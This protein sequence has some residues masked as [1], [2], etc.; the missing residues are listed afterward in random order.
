M[1]LGKTAALFSAALEFGSVIAETSD[2]DRAALKTAGE[3]FGM[4]FQIQDDL[5]DAF[6]EESSDIINKKATCLT[7]FSKEKAEEMAAYFLD[8]ALSS[9]PKNMPSIETIFL[10]YST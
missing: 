2:K 3:Q 7:L 4:A 1:Y 9:L 8:Q 5:A 6:N 10:S